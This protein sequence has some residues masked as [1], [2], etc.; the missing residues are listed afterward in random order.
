[1]SLNG[2]K[3]S[4]AATHFCHLCDIQHDYLE[5][6]ISYD[7]TGMFQLLT[8]FFDRAGGTTTIRA[9][10]TKPL[11]FLY[12]CP[13]TTKMSKNTVTSC[14]VLDF[15]TITLAEYRERSVRKNFLLLLNLSSLLS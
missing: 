6:D 3:E 7:F 11:L 13:V 15:T 10:V 8:V 4:V 5:E 1:M 9:V 2:F 14:N 12:D